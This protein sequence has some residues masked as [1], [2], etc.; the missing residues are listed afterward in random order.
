MCVCVCVCV[1][2]WEGEKGEVGKEKG[3][4][5]DGIR[6]WEALVSIIKVHGCRVSA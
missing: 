6:V 2:V 3:G 1:C 5:R 4:E